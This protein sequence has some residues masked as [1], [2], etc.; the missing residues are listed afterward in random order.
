MGRSREEGA[1]QDQG[2]EFPPQSLS[3]FWGLKVTGSGPAV[4]SRWSGGLRGTGAL[5]AALAPSTLA[6]VVMWPGV[7]RQHPSGR[8][9]P[10]QE[11]KGTHDGAVLDVVVT[12]SC[13]PL[14]C[15]PV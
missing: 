2:L 13:C 5:A 4:G 12:M 1:C 8:D 15:P 10:F 3:G 7:F 9:D 14:Q 6:G 11:G